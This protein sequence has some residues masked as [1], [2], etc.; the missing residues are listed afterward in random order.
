M[1]NE[2]MSDYINITR[3]NKQGCPISSLTFNLVMEVIA[4]KLRQYKDM[5]GI[6]IGGVMKIT[7]Q[8]ADDLLTATKVDQKAFDTQNRLLKVSF[9][10]CQLIMTKLRF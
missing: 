8:Y 2:L 7:S 3:S 9:Q 6:V 5:K 4:C 10:D 1:N